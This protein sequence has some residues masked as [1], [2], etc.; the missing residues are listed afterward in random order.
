L[1]GCRYLPGY[2]WCIDRIRYRKE[3]SW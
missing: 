3:H 2:Q 1:S